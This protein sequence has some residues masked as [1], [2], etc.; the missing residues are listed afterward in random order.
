M[1]PSEISKILQSLRIN[2]DEIPDK[3]ESQTIR[4]LLH[5][6]EE[7][8]KEVQALKAELQK[9]RDELNHLKGEQGKPK[10][11]VPKKN[12]DVSSEKERNTPIS[13]RERKSKEKLSKIKI[14][15]IEDCKVDPSILPEDAVL[16]DYDT[17]VVQ[18]I[19]ITTKTLLIGKKFGTP[20]HNIGHIAGSY[21][22]E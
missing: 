8:N 12:K 1:N 13:R 19:I 14:D 2:P 6:I 5:I 3:Q 20:P 17:V 18:D 15:V 11:P 4:I 16:K 7:L 10:F 22:M 21:Q 9:T